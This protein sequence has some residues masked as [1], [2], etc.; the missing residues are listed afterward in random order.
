VGHADERVVRSR[1]VRIDAL[2]FAG[3]NHGRQR[4]ESMRTRN[5]CGLIVAHDQRGMDLST[6]DET[7]PARMSDIA[8]HLRIAI[9]K[10][11]T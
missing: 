1:K 11:I 7:R 9:M 5:V 8:P 2:S 4:A 3:A 10:G 6:D